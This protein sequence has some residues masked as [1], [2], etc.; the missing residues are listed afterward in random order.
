MSRLSLLVRVLAGLS[1]TAEWCGVQGGVPAP[2]PL[3]LT[4]T[5]YDLSAW[6]LTTQV[7]VDAQGRNIPGDAANE[8][9][10]CVDPTNPERMAIGW[11]Q[12]DS[13]A[14]DARQAGWAYSTNGGLSWTF[15][16]VLETNAFRSDPVL[17]ADADGRFYFLSLRKDPF[18]SDLWLSTDAG[19]SWLSVGPAVGGDKP[20]FV[21][22]TTSSPARGVIYQS[23]SPV[24][25]RFGTRIFSRSLDGGRT[26]TEPIAIPATPVWG[27]L[28][29]DAQGWLYLVGWN[30]SSFWVNRSTNAPDPDASFKFDL[31]TQVDLGGAA[32]IGAGDLNPEGLIGQPWIAVD[33]SSGPTRGNVYVLCSVLA[34]DN[35]VQLMFSRSTDA[36]RTWSPARRLT[37]DS[38]DN[39]AAHWFGALSVAPGGRVD[40]CWF[41][42]RHSPDNSSSELFYAN[43][44]D[45]GVTW[46]KNEPLSGS[47]RQSV[48]YPVQRKIGDYIT[49]T[50]LDDRV[51]IAYAA[52]FNQEEDIFFRRI[53]FPLL[54]GLTAVNGVLTL[55]WKA[56]PG[57]AYF[58]QFKD[59][60]DAPWSVLAGPLPAE[61][62]VLSTQDAAALPHRFYRVVRQP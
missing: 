24:E 26:W 19:V 57:A 4:Q 62:P 27:T 39:R 58:V 2:F 29:I 51:C 18:R 25:N 22:D 54:I 61:G 38:P 60:W 42:T 32:V 33:R 11:R 40:A 3:S 12:F 45:G 48:G 31:T 44:H 7:N 16:G 59:D 34:P 41:D 36:A 46:S 53:E 35:D 13:V 28:D 37:D 9:S 17:G 15:P 8:P 6:P 5:N 43:S 50:S 23:W 30:G 1:F 20:W 14:S 47:F 21:I 56:V 55:S 49:M 10:L 52:T